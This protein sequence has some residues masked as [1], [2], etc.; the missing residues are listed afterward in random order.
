MNVSVKL[1][2]PMTLQQVYDRAQNDLFKNY[3]CKLLL[4]TAD[5]AA[6]FSDIYPEHLFL[7]VES[8]EQ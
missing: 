7:L 6:E 4:S 8:Q 2:G 3:T 1:V 5:S